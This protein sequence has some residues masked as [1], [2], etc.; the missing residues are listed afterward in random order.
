MNFAWGCLALLTLSDV[1][2]FNFVVSSLAGLPS[3]LLR[4]RSFH[5][6]EP[7]SLC[8]DLIDHIDEVTDLLLAEQGYDVLCRK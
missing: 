2:L 4:Q 7:L 1:R 5:V 8:R 3:H 6:D